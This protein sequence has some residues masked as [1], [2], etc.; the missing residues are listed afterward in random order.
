MFD[1]NVEE[2]DIHYYL[3]KK[4]PV[5]PMKVPS[6]ATREPP[7]HSRLE[8]SPPRQIPTGDLLLNARRNKPGR[9]TEPP[10]AEK[11]VTISRFEL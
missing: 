3:T 1:A 10:R 6:E 2:L 5:S 8:D 4:I 9:W 11:T 7:R